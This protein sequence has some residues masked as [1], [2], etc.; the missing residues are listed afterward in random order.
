MAL[1]EAVNILTKAI[2]TL[3]QLDLPELGKGLLSVG[4]AMGELTL[5][6]KF[7]NGTNVNLR[8][9]VA[10]LALAKACDMLGDAVGKF[11]K[12]SWDEITRGLTSMGGALAEVTLALTFLS[13]V[14]GGGA[15]L[16]SGGIFITVQSLQKLAE[17]LK[18]F[19][20]MDWRTI[21]RGFSAMGGALAEVSVAS[22]VLGKLAGF[23][24]ILGGGAILIT[25]QSL[26]KLAEGLQS[27]GG[28]SWDQI[29][30]GLV[31]MGGALAEVGAV[32]GVLGK[33]AGFSGIF[34]AGA[35]LITVQGLGQ[36]A[37]GLKSFGEMQWDEIGRG[38]VAMGG[39]LLEVGGISG[40]LG[41]L[42]GFSG[43]FG[44]GT[45]W[46][47]VQGLED[48]AISFQKFSQMTWSEI[49][50]GLVAMGGALAEVSVISGA[51]GVLTGF[52]GILGGASI[53]V[54]VQGL[55]DLAV[56][57]K[58]FASMNWDEIGRGLT[59]MGAAMA[60]TAIGGLLNTLSGFGANA[61]A[62][63]AGPLGTLA[64][65]VK[66]WGGVT[67][68]E[69]LGL[70]IG[71]LA[72]GIAA[73]NFAG[74]GA[75]A[76]AS[77]AGPLGT[78]AT[79]VKNWTGVV[80]PA[81]LPDQ[82]ADLSVGVSAFNFSGWGADAIAAVAPALGNLAISM[83][84]WETVSIPEGLGTDLASLASGVDA[85]SFAFVGG[86]SISSLI[87]PLKD[88][89]DTIRTWNTVRIPENIEE[90]MASL[91]AGV[92]SFSFGSG[93]TLSG[94]V[95]PLGDL[96]DALRKWSGISLAGIGD[97]LVKLSSA[98]EN[99]NG[100]GI[101]E[102]LKSFD[103]AADTI[104]SSVEA[105]MNAITN[106]IT[107]KRSSVVSAYQLLA[108]ASVEAISSKNDDFEGSGETAAGRFI[109][110][111]EG[112]KTDVINAFLNIIS[113]SL[114]SI[115][116]ERRSFQ[117]AGSYI[118]D[119]L[120]VGIQN[121]AYKA[122]AQA[123]SLAQ[124]V[125]T[126]SEGAL[127]VNSPSTVFYGIG[128]Y[129]ILG[130]VKGI[131]D[132]VRLAKDAS[133]GL[134]RTVEEG[135]EETLQIN[136]PSVVMNELG[137]YTV[138]GL[139]E[140]ITEDMSAE[141]AA[142]Q[143]A[144]NIVSA[145]QTELDKFDTQTNTADLEYELWEKQYSGTA[146]DAQKTSAEINNLTKKFQIEGEKVKLAQGEYQVTLENFGSTSE[147]T[148]QA[149]N[150]LLEAQISL[151][152]ITEQLNTAQN[153]LVQQNRDS[154]NK[155]LEY[156]NQNKEGLLAAGFSLEEI[157]KAAMY[158]T[159][160]NPEAMSQ[161]MSVQVQMAVTDAMTTV[162]TAYQQSAQTTFSGLM[163]D[164]TSIGTG[165]ATSIGTGVKTQTPAVTQNI[166]DML[167]D[168]T[169]TIT[170][171]QQ[172]WID[173]GRYSV[174]GFAQGIKES[175]FMAEIEAAAM[176][177]AAYEA[178]MAALAAASPSKLFM[179]VGSYIPMGFALGIKNNAGDVEDSAN[180]MAQT[181]IDSTRS[182]IS[183]LAAAIDDGIDTQPTIRPVLD[184]SGVQTGAHQ[185]DTMFTRNQ[186]LSIN[187][188]VSRTVP[189]NDQN[190]ANS[191]NSAPVYQFTQNNYSPKALSRIDIY[192]QTKNQFSAFG[193]VVKT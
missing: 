61:I 161:D 181:A 80:V 153:T 142:A 77:M 114:L 112:K 97:D 160:Y 11:S 90:D 164:F 149:Y 115:R 178:A 190:G 92:G 21:S 172:D 101:K 45:I 25:V 180:T 174:E 89:A 18:S 188:G 88:L 71:S 27:F 84:N 191:G 39:A 31:G 137:H 10:M 42:A 13:K 96:G 50:R 68:P 16:G 193:R 126:A 110:G 15:L 41:K 152:G 3:S 113:A 98:V 122:I 63:M 48:L 78:L 74:W 5:A 82:L 129:I 177:K 49:G 158:E 85:F 139:A 70:Q 119:G 43:I 107:Q 6:L 150:K 2:A 28:M 166:S 156:M 46:I 169:A 165:M 183:R 55:D 141:E 34:G 75:D 52:A 120:A 60:E 56:A 163:T 36:L 67:V 151:A 148:Q 62:S 14:G 54:T 32:T 173:A 100:A 64:D 35:I 65:S 167:A 128:S 121:N 185:L 187:T 130:L 124:Q 186:A 53:W 157:K 26:K 140:G 66:K 184:L 175:A 155:Y 103:G 154:V 44:A 76:I 33:L 17:G 143:K 146:T 109:M 125:R 57:F 108:N 131:R 81:E 136:S 24:G 133:V 179:Q 111:A 144:Q 176:A 104:R 40:A 116:A 159:G 73:F 38:L 105:I 20:E 19:G 106:T 93:W 72:S 22:G 29:N 168:C 59:A 127:G 145:F 79:S 47:A 147:H 51:L 123:K 7:L 83:K 4:I 95:E 23:S 171:A 9:S 117:D 87:Q 162:Q 170:S 118:V 99:F 91:A 102:L 30:H 69:G 94:V 192:R 182:A 37:D 132:N 134:G 1:A 138:Q 8:T 135:V 12:L 86:W 58:K 189:S